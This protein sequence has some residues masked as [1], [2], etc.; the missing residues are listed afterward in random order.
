MHGSQA[1][2]LGGDSKS[3]LRPGP[4]DRGL[5]PF[6]FPFQGRKSALRSQ[7]H[8]KQFFRYHL[9]KNQIILKK[10]Y[11]GTRLKEK[12][13]KVSNDFPLLTLLQFPYGYIP[14]LQHKRSLYL[15]LSRLDQSL[16]TRPNRPTSTQF[17][18]KLKVQSVGRGFSFS[19]TNTSG[20]SGEFPSPK[21]EPSEL[22]QSYIRNPAKSSKIKLD[23]VRSRPD[24]AGL[25]Q[26]WPNHGKFQLKFVDFGEKFAD[27]KEVLQ[28]LTKFVDS[29]NNLQFLAN[30][31]TD[32]TNP[33]STQTRN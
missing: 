32:R 3:P 6:P 2:K 7:Y 11:N 28:I 15:G 20:S 1:I 25:S 27:S 14:H 12:L 29:D 33:S 23:L 19:R 5:L 24:L 10:T 21:P 30:F 22:D 8:L 13:L 9:L 26:I 31:S 16:K 18:P 4:L 17:R